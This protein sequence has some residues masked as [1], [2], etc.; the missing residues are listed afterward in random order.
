MTRV[1]HSTRGFGRDRYDYRRHSRVEHATADRSTTT[2]DTSGTR[3][4]G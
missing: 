2:R 3:R 4:D 1:E